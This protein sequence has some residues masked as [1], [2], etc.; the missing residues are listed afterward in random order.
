MSKRRYAIE[1]LQQRFDNQQSVRPYVVLSSCRLTSL[2]TCEVATIRAV[3]YVTVH[4]D[5]GGLSAACD[6]INDRL[7]ANR[8]NQG[9]Q[10]TSGASSTT[11]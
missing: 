7:S 3:Q 11:L 1:V 10:N 5:D 6:V 9:A 4:F 8:H 2:S